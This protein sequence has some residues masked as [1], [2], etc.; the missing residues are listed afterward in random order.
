LVRRI[1]IKRLVGLVAKSKIKSYIYTMTIEQVQTRIVEI[2]LTLK[3]R[4]LTDWEQDELIDE[5]DQLIAILETHIN[6]NLQD[7]NDQ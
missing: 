5:L 3:K 1:R 2:E 4:G 6:Q 7:E